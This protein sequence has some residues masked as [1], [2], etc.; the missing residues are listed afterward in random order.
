MQATNTRGAPPA[1]ADT[2]FRKTD[3]CH[4]LCSTWFERDRRH[5]RLET[6]LG[7]MIFELW[8]EAVDEAIIDGFLTVPQGTR[9]TESDWQPHAVRYAEERG[10]I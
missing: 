9:L 2:T 10:L 3:P 5:I 8:D 1:F 6:P 4:Y 7:R